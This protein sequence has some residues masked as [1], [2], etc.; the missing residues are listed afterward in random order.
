MIT[1][2]GLNTRVPYHFLFYSVVFGGTAFYSFIIAPLTFKKLPREEFSNLQTQVFPSYFL[3]QVVSPVVLGLTTPLK[4]CPLSLGVLALSS[5][6]G[7]LNLWW[8]LPVSR[9]IKE[10]RQKLVADKLDKTEAGDDTEELTRLNKLFAK[11][12]GISSLVNLVSI[13]SVAFY[14]LLLAKKLRF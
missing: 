6:A 14:G 10:Q 9:G 12:H 11:F 2:L 13:T 5:V 4:P 1:A 3:T 7:A 8:L